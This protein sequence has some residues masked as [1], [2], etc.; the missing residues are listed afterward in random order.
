MHIAFMSS[1][2]TDGNPTSG[3]E[4]ANEAIVQGL[5]ALGHKVSVIGFSVPRQSK[6]TVKDVVVV[7]ELNLENAAVGGLQKLGFVA[8][9]IKCGLPIS[10]SKLTVV[11]RDKL[12]AAIRSCGEVDRYIFNSYQMAAAFPHLLDQPFGFVT[13]NV[14]HVSAA[15]NAVS[16][17]SKLQ[18]WLYARDARL[19]ESI[20]AK[21]CEQAQYVW[22]LSADDLATLGLSSDKSAVLPLVAPFIENASAINE[23]EFDIGMIGTWSWEPNRVG[24][25]WF[26]NKVVPK[27]PEDFRI[28]IAGK[29]PEAMINPIGKVW[30][31]GRVESASDFLESVRIVPLISQGGTGVQLKTIEAF[32]A[33]LACVATSSSLRGIENLPAN[34]AKADSVGEFVNSLI[35]QVEN[36]RKGKLATVDGR[37]FYD[38]QFS[39]MKDA[40]VKGLKHVT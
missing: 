30:F 20:E 39:D 12:D 10:A 23:K 22:A 29:V 8:R 2:V 25:E 21:L 18:R 26:L 33:G 36:S 19:L 16:A 32:Q 15:Q 6:N 13:H 27:L 24:L 38:R 28:A 17:R 3:F 11:G 37:Q 5:R 7:E 9:A 40:L 35:S 31:L 14:E 4:I 1:V 34:C